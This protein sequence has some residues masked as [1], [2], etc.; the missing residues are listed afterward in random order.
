MLMSSRF[1]KRLAAAI[2]RLQSE[3]LQVTPLSPHMPDGWYISRDASL[4]V[5]IFH[6]RETGGVRYCVGSL[7]RPGTALADTGSGDGG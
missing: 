6:V 2:E 3:N 5:E 4:L 7:A 1:E